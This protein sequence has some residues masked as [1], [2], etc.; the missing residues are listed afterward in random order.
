[1]CLFTKQHVLLYSCLL[2]KMWL[3]YVSCLMHNETLLFLKVIAVKYCWRDRN[4]NV[5]GRWYLC[6]QADCFEHLRC[7]HTTG[8]VLT[9]S[10]KERVVDPQAMESLGTGMGLFDLLC[11]CFNRSHQRKG[12]CCQQTSQETNKRLILENAESPSRFSS[13][14]ELMFGFL[15]VCYC[16]SLCKRSNTPVFKKAKIFVIQVDSDLGPSLRMR[17]LFL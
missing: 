9:R 11:G 5:I 12:Q 17:D 15:A 3:V 10:R 1:M 8:I 2:K 16:F 4:V 13:Q 6:S 7:K 14:A